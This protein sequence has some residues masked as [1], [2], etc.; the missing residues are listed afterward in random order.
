MA[1]ASVR[2]ALTLHSPTYR[3]CVVTPALPAGFGDHAEFRLCLPWEA[4]RA[5][6]L[7]ASV[8][9]DAHTPKRSMRE[10]SSGTRCRVCVC[11]DDQL[12]FCRRRYCVAAAGQV[13]DY[14]RR[15]KVSFYRD[16]V[17]QRLWRACVVQRLWRACVLN[18]VADI[19]WLRLTAVLLLD[20]AS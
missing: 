4:A 16:R 6:A 20:N 11:R 19:P 17:V 7:G 12:V 14:C 18:V 2:N 10:R 5:R 1:P 3:T 9:G 15:Q 8:A 13:F